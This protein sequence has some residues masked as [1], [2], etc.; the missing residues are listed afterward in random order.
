MTLPT[1]AN[2]TNP[3]A[4][5]FNALL[6]SGTSELLLRVPAGP[7]RELQIVDEPSAAR[8]T[9]TAEVPEEF[10]DSVGREF[11]RSDFTGGQGLAFAHRRGLT[12]RDATRFFDSYGVDVSP[13]N[14]G[15]EP[16]VT[17][18]R[19]T[20]L[21]DAT[22]NTGLRVAV[23][24]AGKL[25]VTSGQTLRIS[26]T[27]TGTTP[28]FSD[29]SP[30][31]A[32]PAANVTGV[33]VAG[34]EVFA[35]VNGNGIHRYTGSW[36]DDFSAVQAD[37]VWWINGRLFASVAT[38]LNEISLADGTATE[39]N[40]LAA[41]HTWTGMTDA[42]SHV[43]ASSDDGTVYSWQVDE[44]GALVQTGQTTID[45]ET[46]EGVAASG[47]TVMFVTGQTTPA[48][49]RRGRWY[50]AT[51]NPDGVLDPREVVVEWGD[52]TSTIVEFGRAQVVSREA[53]YAFARH[54]ANRVDCWRYDLT[55][56]GVSRHWSFPAAGSTSRPCVYGAALVNATMVATVEGSGV[57]RVSPTVEYLPDGEGQ[58][59]VLGYL[60][61]P[62]AD[63][64]TASDKI[65]VSL[66]VDGDF[67]AGTVTRA[68]YT[69][70]PAAIHDP[71]H[72]SW[73]FATD[74]RPTFGTQGDVEVQLPNIRGRYL[75]VMLRV[76]AADVETVTATPRIRSFGV[77]ALA[78]DPDVVVTF[79]ANVSDRVERRGRHGLHVPGRGRRTYEALRGYSGRAVTLTIYEPS[80]VV[81]GTVET[82]GQRVLGHTDRGSPLVYAMVT[83]RGK[84]RIV[85]VAT[86]A[87][88]GVGLEWI[89]M[90]GMG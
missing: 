43:L 5:G 74:V 86:P 85:V 4:R 24:P 65:W 12:P 16:A 61:S 21:V 60:I 76:V 9:D 41:G 31:D 35:A 37:N 58:G 68:F 29:E 1:T 79:P 15:E 89:G 40:T 90:E 78:A 56:A 49:G 84:R 80:D 50:K 20:E 8:Q 22:T 17:L 55:T 27:P 75:S 47:Q 32:D 64:Y 53:F 71:E 73:M 34:T 69:T 26:T 51:L 10:R 82:I 87:E 39:L 67:P 46:V 70:D 7:G 52:L 18:L 62:L 14:L 38:V 23:S 2:T 77:R 72:S 42:G 45:G 88:T 63:F 3:R 59:S 13:P 57:W 11:A 66:R 19:A 25:Y 6:D 36:A 48:G 83:V 28:P 54:G 81:H 44:S 30:H 33:A